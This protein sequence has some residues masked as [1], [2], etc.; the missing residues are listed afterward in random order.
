[1]DLTIV[2]CSGSF[3]GPDSASSCYLLEA[4]GYRLVLDLGNGALGPLQRYAGLDQIDAV[5]LS[6]LHADHC[7][8]M[9]SYQVYR[10]YNPTG[11]LPSIPLYGPPESV[12]RLDRAS[13]AESS[14][15]MASSFD[16]TALTAGTFEIGP[17][18]VTTR[19]M[20]HPVETFGF[21]ISQGGA[22]LA[23]S[24]D[25]GESDELVELARDADLLLCE[26][27]FADLDLD[28]LPANLHLS[29]GQAGE[30]AARAGVGELLLTHLVP[31]N[32]QDDVL[33]RA[34]ARYDGPVSLAVPGARITVGQR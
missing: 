27:S 31:W 1:M 9:C 30:H 21:R 29:A 7:I 18:R 5:C 20:N 15:S 28:G 12:L 25:T 33:T 32:P 14:A 26:A 23:Y 6:H 22:T 11:H 19:H 24:A 8:D 4:D 10:T 16:F 34:A 2:G 17:F 13:G 3:P